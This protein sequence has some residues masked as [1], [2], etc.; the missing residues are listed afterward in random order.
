MTKSKRKL[1]TGRST[2][3]GKTGKTSRA[4]F[5]AKQFP[6]GESLAPRLQRL[7]QA[8]AAAPPPSNR[9][10]LSHE[11]CQALL[12]FY[13]ESEERNEDVRARYPAVKAHLESC[14]ECRFSYQLLKEPPV[15]DDVP[16]VFS[17]S[18][19]A[20]PLPFLGPSTPNEAWTG[21]RRSRIAGAPLGFGYQIQPALYDQRPVASPATILRSGESLGAKS[22]LVS[23]SLTL[24]KYDITVDAW[25]FPRQA[26]G[27]AKVEVSLA[28]SETL[29]GPV[30]VT[31]AAGDLAYHGVIQEG[32][33]RFDDIPLSEIKGRHDWHVEFEI[34]EAPPAAQAP[35]TKHTL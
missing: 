5:T 32:G 10:I 28:A 19:P 16:D 25:L 29:P 33:C 3:V 18:K 4:R 23:D 12:E 31:L 21:Y 34:G 8:I 6:P 13:V 20:R 17:A 24:S 35:T 9:V 15:A 26:Q 27:M 11:E 7:A 14:D 2:R 1:E 30:R 22:L